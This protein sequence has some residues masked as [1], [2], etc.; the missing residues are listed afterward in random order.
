M[1][2]PH[3]LP[4]RADLV[5]I[6]RYIASMRECAPSPIRGCVSAGGRRD[7]HTSRRMTMPHRYLIFY[8]ATED[9]NMIY[10]RHGDPS[11]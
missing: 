3:S 9:E 2:L 7:G 4:A 8:E 10:V 1:R 6:P 11:N 5:S